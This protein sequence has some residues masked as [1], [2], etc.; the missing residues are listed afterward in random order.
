MPGNIKAVI[1]DLD[2]TVLYTLDDLT[3]SC[4][5]ALKAMG[6]G[7]RP[8]EDIRKFVGNGMLKL[9]YR[10]FPEGTPEDKINST[11]KI[12]V[13]HYKDHCMDMTRPY[14]GIEDVIKSLRKDG[15]KTG[16]VSNKTDEA[17]QPIIAHYFPGLFDAV[18]GDRPGITRKPDPALLFDTMDKLGVPLQST[19]YVGD[20]DVD[21]QTAKNAGIPCISVTWGYRDKDFLSRCGAS[22]FADSPGDILNIINTL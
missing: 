15:I 2:G 18:T 16:I 9:I 14:D 21:I 8:A 5:Y 13:D 17:V 4:N 12:F 11:M 3:Y 6:Y 7:E 19:V 22:L 10:L 1:F 20:S